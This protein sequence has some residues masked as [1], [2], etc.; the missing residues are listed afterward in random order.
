[1]N[2]FINRQTDKQI[3]QGTSR[4]FLPNDSP[5]S[6]V[7]R[8]NQALLRFD[9]VDSPSHAMEQTPNV[10][11]MEII[12]PCPLPSYLVDRNL[13]ECAGARANND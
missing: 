13:R 3:S 10:L 4:S 11:C 8:A 6:V 9:D 1:M 5:R 2:L 7:C 12:L